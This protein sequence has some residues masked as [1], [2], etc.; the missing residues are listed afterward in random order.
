M[1]TLRTVWLLHNL[2]L[3][4]K[5]CLCDDKML[6]L[7]KFATLRN[8]VESLQAIMENVTLCAHISHKLFFIG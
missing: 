6:R 4:G 1:P 7:Y 2:S 5:L 8:H 3:D